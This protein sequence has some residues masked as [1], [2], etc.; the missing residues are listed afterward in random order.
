MNPKEMTMSSAL[1]IAQ[2]L[3]A[4]LPKQHKVSGRRAAIGSWL[5]AMRTM[6]A[7]LCEGF[8]AYRRYEHLKSWRVSDDKAVRNA[9]LK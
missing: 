1:Q 5:T 6:C 8:A 9:L 4:I 7:G 3:N 2:D